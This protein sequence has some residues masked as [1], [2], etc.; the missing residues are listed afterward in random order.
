MASL[1][2][3]K[4]DILKP[5]RRQLV[6]L[7]QTKNEVIYHDSIDL[8][9]YLENL[10]TSSDVTD[11][12]SQQ[13]LKN[14]IASKSMDIEAHSIFNN[15]LY[16]GFKAPLNSKGK[17]VIFKLS[18]VNAMFSGEQ[19]QGGIWQLLDLKDDTS[20]EPDMLSDMLLQGNRMLLLS[21]K[22]SKYPVSYLWS[23]HIGN[24][25]LTKLATF[26][27]L[28]AEGIAQ[29]IFDE[30]E[31]VIVFDTGTKFASRHLILNTKDLA[32]AGGM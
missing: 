32:I 19:K 11:L 1:S 20:G 15:D 22:T 27:N 4:K 13:F 25:K 24:K 9:S 7:Q 26:K 8:Y 30:N 10:S 6:R 14:A 16:L 31:N 12:S 17:S 28:K 21:V 18:D 3:N 29:S 23:Y 5:K 2:Q